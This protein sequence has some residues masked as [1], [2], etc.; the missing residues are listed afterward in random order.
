MTFTGEAGWP[1]LFRRVGD[2]NVSTINARQS[3]RHALGEIHG[4]VLARPLAAAARL[5]PCGVRAT[6]PLRG[7]RISGAAEGHLKM[8]AAI[9]LVLF[10]RL[11]DKRLARL[12]ERLDG[13]RETSEEVADGLVAPV[14]RPRTGWAW[15][16]NRTHSHAGSCDR[17]A[18]H[19]L[20]SF[21]QPDRLRRQAH[22]H[23]R[24]GRP[25]FLV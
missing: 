24:S 23:S 6:R 22:F 13:L 25:G 5:T 20:R 19:S 4:A 15:L 14:S 18:A 16:G 17:F 12:K 3:L 1:V 8:V 9:A 10:D 2:F 7:G 21:G 11:A